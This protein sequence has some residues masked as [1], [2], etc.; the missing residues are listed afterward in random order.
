MLSE[1][2]RRGHARREAGAFLLGTRH[3]KVARIRHALYYDDVA[4]GSLDS[5][6][7][8][9]PA[10]AYSALWDACD[11]LGL[12]VVA[13]VHTHPGA[14]GQSASDQAHPMVPRPGHLALIIPS[15]AMRPTKHDMGFYRFEGIGDWSTLP[16]SGCSS[17][18]YISLLS[19]P[20]MGRSTCTNS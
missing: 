3:G 10:R 4:P 9:L 18:L 1:L 6:I 12:E 17:A 14:A 19:W 11:D 8:R 16:T 20:W 15:Y 2:R 7:V 5:G 13:D